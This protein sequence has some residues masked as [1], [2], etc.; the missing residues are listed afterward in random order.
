MG[1]D[2][3]LLAALAV[4][5]VVNGLLLV[6]LPLQ[7]RTRGSPTGPS[8]VHPGPGRPPAAGMGVRTARA[9]PSVSSTDHAGPVRKP[10]DRLEPVDD[11]IVARRIEAFVRAGRA[12]RED[13]PASAIQLRSAPVAARSETVPSIRAAGTVGEPIAV[14]HATRPAPS[15]WTPAGLTDQDAWDRAVMGATS[16]AA[17]DRRPATIVMARLDQLDRVADRLGRPAS[18][19][20]LEEIARS[21]LG[22]CRSSDRVAWLGDA[23]FG[24]L[25]VETDEPAAR[26]YVD[27][28]RSACNE[29]LEVSGLAVRATFELVVLSAGD[30]P[31]DVGRRTEG[32]P[33]SS[34]RP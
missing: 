30:P 19:R 28:V 25:L 34:H 26:S 18:E 10:D 27:R 7:A 32:H 16:G 14:L 11:S 3:I 20:I 24:T 17:V 4:A 1:A 12:H 15:D 22:H 6:A 2:P 5:I 31:S 13:E 33:S 23:T 9:A 8:D 21:L 29:W